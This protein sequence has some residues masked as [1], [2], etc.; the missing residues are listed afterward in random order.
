MR[1]LQERAQR[2]HFIGIGGSGLSAIARLLLESGYTV[3]GSDRTLSPLAQDLAAAGARV[4]AGHQAENIQGADMV[5]RSSAIPDSNIEVQAALAAGIPVLKRAQ[6][7]GRL[8][9]NHLAIAVAGT[10]GKTTITAMISWLLVRLGQDPSYIIGGTAKNLDGRNAHAGKGRAFVIEADEYD[11]MFL[12]LYP[13]L[14]V[15]SSVEHDHPDCF[16]TPQDY[17]AAFAAF[18]HQLRTGGI[19]LAAHDNSAAALLAPAIPA[20]TRAFSY[21]TSP[22]AS[23]TA[24]A[25]VL[26]QH[27]GY[28]F[29]VW[30]P[31]ADGQKMLLTRVSLQV[32]G[33]HN[34]RNGLA[35]LAAIYLAGFGSSGLIQQAAQALNEFVGTGRRFDILGTINGITVIDDYA[36]NP[37]KIQATLSAARARYPGQRIWAVWQPHTFSRTLA[38]LDDFTRSFAAA[39]R[40]L[41]TEIYAAREKASDFDNFSAAQVVKQ[42]DHPAAQFTPSL[43]ETSSFLLSQLQP[44]DVVLVL[45]AGDADQVSAGVLSA[46]KERSKTHA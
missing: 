43:Q 14:I 15:V 25:P 7:L 23:F 12:G 16:P 18:V 5:V 2:I 22:D 31:N 30:A 6:F 40:V 17:T 11:R 36:H 38:F 27:G 37:A 8:M 32:P 21:G 20:E 34:M 39:D 29:E 1:T 45:S 24:A 19:L 42:I 3:S 4:F 28:D 9:E 13:D 35:A 41:V 46:L 10:H 26:N 33:E 44:G